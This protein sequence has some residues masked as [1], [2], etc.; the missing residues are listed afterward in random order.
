[1]QRKPGCLGSDAGVPQVAGG[2]LQ[3]CPDN[4]LHR[5]AAGETQRIART[6][7][8]RSC[9]RQ[10]VPSYNV[11]FPLELANSRRAL[12]DSIR[13]DRNLC[14]DILDLQVSDPLLV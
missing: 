12:Q 13:N 3:A 14:D 8:G 6:F 2:L 11:P 1:M 4:E 9:I 5:I 10:L 7:P